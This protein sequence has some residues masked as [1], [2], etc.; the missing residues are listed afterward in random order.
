VTDARHAQ[1]SARTQTLRKNLLQGCIKQEEKARRV[2]RIYFQEILRISVIK[3]PQNAK[4][5]WEVETF[6]KGKLRR[7]I[8]FQK[9]SR[10]LRNGLAGD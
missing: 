2:G 5:V 3:N 8:T 10:D 9:C 7:E 6:T 1:T 4:S